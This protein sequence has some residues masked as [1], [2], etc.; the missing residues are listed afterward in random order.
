MHIKPTQPGLRSIAFLA[1][2]GLGNYT[3]FG[4]PV[5]W[6]GLYAALYTLSKRKDNKKKNT[7]SL[8]CKLKN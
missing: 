7:I 5:G 6:A 1:Q 3:Q 2:G 4:K 8:K